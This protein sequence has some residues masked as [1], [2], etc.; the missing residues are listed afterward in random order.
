M[1]IRKPGQKLEMNSTK[2]TDFEILIEKLSVIEKKVDK[3]LKITSFKP[4]K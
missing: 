2:K 1:K 3:L 4:T